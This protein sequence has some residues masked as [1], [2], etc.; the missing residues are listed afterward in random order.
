MPPFVPL[1][2]DDQWFVVSAQQHA[3]LC[4]DASDDTYRG[5]GPMWELQPSAG[6]R[7]QVVAAQ[8]EVLL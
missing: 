3:D 7:S 5:T 8:D 2:A 6:M 4:T 1:E